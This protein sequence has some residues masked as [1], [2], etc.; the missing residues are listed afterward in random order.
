MF[1]GAAYH[2]FAGYGPRTF[3]VDFQTGFHTPP[4]D[5]QCVEDTFFQHASRPLEVHPYVAAMSRRVR[6]LGLGKGAF[7]SRIVSYRRSPSWDGTEY[8]RLR[9]AT[10]TGR[11]VL[12]IFEALVHA[13]G[14]AHMLQLD[15]GGGV[16][17]MHPHML[18]FHAHQLATEGCGL[19]GTSFNPRLTRFNPRKGA[20]R[21]AYAYSVAKRL[22]ALDHVDN[23]DEYQ[24]YEHGR[25][26]SSAAFVHLVR[27]MG[28]APAQARARLLK[29]AALACARPMRR[30][31]DV[32][33]L[34]PEE[35][36]LFAREAS[37]AV[38]R[39]LAQTPGAAYVFGDAAVH[40]Y[41]GG[42][43]VFG[44]DMSLGVDA[45]PPVMA[46]VIRAVDTLSRSPVIQALGRRIRR[47]GGGDGSF[48]AFAANGTVHLRT[49]YGGSLM[50][51]LF[52]LTVHTHGADFM[53][54]TTWNHSGVAIIHPHALFFAALSRCQVERAA[55]IA[56]MLS[57]MPV[58]ADAY[59]FMERESILSYIHLVGQG[60]SPAQARLMLISACRQKKGE[61]I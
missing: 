7:S 29:G 5:P 21:L 4:E 52:R 31:V 24:S 47:N 22:R 11:E 18:F 49:L 27:D 36:T 19:N 50:W 46:D 13:H 32:G 30:E 17:I 56:D 9:L 55:R 48:Y 34:P 44:I 51:D 59:R 39:L 58:E 3:D 57:E 33:L 61:N 35:L 1:G 54:E 10:Y 60:V 12:H 28:L 42:E 15:V 20:K 14:A 41:A 53:R 45:S 8:F 23:L 25:G 38:W 2:V 6:L 40:L 43:P 26:R 37:D 16:Q